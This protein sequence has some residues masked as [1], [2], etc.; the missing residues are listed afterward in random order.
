M[1]DLGSH[2]AMVLRNH[3]LLA[4]GG[5]VRDAFMLM[6]NFEQSCRIQVDAMA[7][8]RDRLTLISNATA[9][10][11]HKPSR[12]NGCSIAGRICST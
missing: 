7:A 12:W 4:L 9:A 3:G 1:A 11:Q 8:G 6:Y 5:T 10:P 2:V